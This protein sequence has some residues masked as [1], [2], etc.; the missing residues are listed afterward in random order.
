MQRLVIAVIMITLM[1]Q[2]AGAEGAFSVGDRV[3]TTSDINLKVRDNP[4]ISSNVI[5][6]VYKGTLGTINDG[7]VNRDNY[8][9]WKIDYD[10]GVTGWSAENW[11]EI[12]PTSLPQAPD[13]FS[14]WGEQAIE[15]GE[16][17]KDWN[18]WNGLCMRFV[19]DA[20]A[21]KDGLP[22]GLNADGWAKKLYRFNQG[23]EGWL[24][25]PKGAVIFFDSDKEP[26]N[27]KLNTHGHVGIYLGEG[28]LIHAYG[29]VNETTID[30]AIAKAGVGKYIGWSYPPE[31][32]RPNANAEGSTALSPTST[33]QRTNSAESQSSIS[34]DR[35][36]GIDVSDYQGTIDWSS[37]AASGYKF[38]F[39]KATE[40]EGWTGDSEAKQQNFESNIA[41]A[42]S[43]GM[44]AG[45][46]HFAR[47]DL[48]NNATDEA[49]WFV[50]VAGGYIKPG[51]LRPVLDI[52]K[53]AGESEADLSK[54]I[55]EW[56]DTVKRETGVEPM[57]YTSA[58]FAADNGLD[59]SLAKYNLWVA[60]WTYDTARSPATG[61]WDG[62]D[63]WQYSNKGE[64]P[65]I[66]GDVDLDLFIGS[67][68][69]LSNFIITEVS[70]L[71]IVQ[72]F[73]VTPQSLNLGESVAIDYTV[74]DSDGSGLA[75]VELW[76]K[77]ET[78]EWQQISTN[79]LAGET[80]S[81][82]GSFTDSPTA[83]G[84]YWYGVHVVDNAGNWNDER[85]SN[86]NGQPSGFEPAEVVAANVDA[87]NDH[88]VVLS[89]GWDIFNGPI[90]SGSVSWNVVG[91][92]LKVEFEVS[93]AQPNHK[94]VLMATFFDPDSNTKL[95]DIDQIPS[96]TKYGAS[97]APRFDCCREGLCASGPGEI[98]FGYMNTN[99]NG[100]GTSQFDF[101]M[102]TGIY[103]TQF[104]IRIGGECWPGKG[105]YSGCGVVYRTGN[106]YG[107]G[108]EKIVII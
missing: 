107:D 103:Y 102:P 96:W 80:D 15:W 32:W 74:S 42:S 29:K 33:E 52:E 68:E 38:A 9:W 57:I 63:F 56:I 69:E 59:A 58:S 51:Y 55:N 2:I 8:N 104:S 84:K 89:P 17:R 64:V 78:S 98:T 37:V 7:P 11:L 106:K 39:V 20:F 91:D 108:F 90:S 13:D 41:G 6:S 26:V 16:K 27:G 92:I 18:D 3:W 100:D 21:Q 71:P 43:A 88:Y 67:R 35:A 25:A 86:S 76:R 22:A 85:N 66:N 61:F 97:V 31:S 62:W 101:K 54:W 49:R 83:P 82:S 72:A 87:M 10:I 93:G 94:Y 5:D 40:G 34:D 105:D 70:L 44:L 23:P 45:A 50:N 30:E 19:V 12:S 65:G 75:Q 24:Q 4:G 1:A 46:Y 47:P 53:S 36:M 95:Q 14:Q 81:V 99:S 48:G 60:H 77:D 73:Q 28:K 79:P